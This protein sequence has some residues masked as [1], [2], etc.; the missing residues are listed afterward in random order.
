MSTIIGLVI[1]AVAAIFLFRV[2]AL[3]AR[4]AL[5]VILLIGILI[6]LVPLL[7]GN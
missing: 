5:S 1:L 3:A 6:M 4:V 2:T 7:I